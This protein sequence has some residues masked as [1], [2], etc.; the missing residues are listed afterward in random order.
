M[1]SFTGLY[2]YT[3]IDGNRWKLPAASVQV[4]DVLHRLSEWLDYK[5]K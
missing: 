3:F 5:L 2:I 1:V 4:D